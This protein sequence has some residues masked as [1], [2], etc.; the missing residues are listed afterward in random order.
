MRCRPFVFHTCFLESRDPRTRDVLHERSAHLSAA[1][2]PAAQPR[3][4]QPS[5]GALGRALGTEPLQVC[6]TSHPAGR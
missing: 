6:P 1:S 3:N 2:F 4:P 5:P